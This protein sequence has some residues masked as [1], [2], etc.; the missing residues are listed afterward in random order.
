MAEDDDKKPK[1]N[2]SD[3][4][5]NKALVLEPCERPLDPGRRGKPIKLKAN[6]FRLNLIAKQS[7]FKYTV[8]T[9]LSPVACSRFQT[10][11]LTTSALPFPRQVQITTVHETKKPRILTKELR[12]IWYAL[13]DTELSGKTNHFGGVRVV[14][15]G[16]NACFSADTLPGTFLEIPVELRSRGRFIIT[17]FNPAEIRPEELNKWASA[18]PVSCHQ[19][20]AMDALAALNTLFIHCL[21]GKDFP[22]TKNVFHIQN[23][24]DIPGLDPRLHAPL[25]VGGGIQLWRGFFQSVRATPAIEYPGLFT[26]VNCTSGAFYKPG[27]LVEFIKNFLGRR[28]DQELNASTIDDRD[29]IYLKRLLKNVRVDAEFNEKTKHHGRPIKEGITITSARTTFFFDSSKAN[30]DDPDD[31]GK[32]ISVEDFFWEYYGVRLRQP[33]A[34]CVRINERVSWPAELCSITPGIKYN[35][36]L[37]SRQQ[38]MASNA[39]YQ[40]MAP[41]DRMRAILAVG[42]ESLK[43]ATGT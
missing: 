35:K 43:I 34:P 33:H 32:E 42:N 41:R 6:V 39:K 38:E 11:P 22:S 17:L 23:P 14:Y 31:K 25:D 1:P 7:W 24:N 27:N 26:N 8:H 9:F 20:D 28:Q 4:P 13:E 30:K 15:D 16:R 5:P 29:R 19:G 21:A 2:P 18:K 36:K 3:V 10:T 12:Q 37:N 40:A